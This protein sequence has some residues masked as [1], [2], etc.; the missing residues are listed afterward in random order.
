[1]LRL[2]AYD[3]NAESELV[4]KGGHGKA[5]TVR[6]GQFLT[7]TDVQ[8]QQVGDFFAWNRHDPRE[9]LSPHNTRLAANALVPPVG[10]RFVTNRRRP[11]FVLVRDTVG[12]HD[13]M[14][15]ACDPARYAGFGVANHRSCATN[16]EEALRETGVVV[17]R[18]YD[19]VNLFMNVP[20]RDDGSLSIEL[21]LS[22]PGDAVTFRATLDTL[23][24][25][26]A[27]PMDLNAC[28]GGPITD[29]HV[30]IH[31]EADWL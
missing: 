9:F 23:C 6:V 29:L 15:A 4:V 8:G 20:V 28:N 13:L 27:C 11:M 3:R 26:S 17:P 1:M 14:L 31:N 12:R 18:L 19:P 10:S 24:A 25:L 30:R 5:F 21:P 16:A 7:I 22:R 2:R